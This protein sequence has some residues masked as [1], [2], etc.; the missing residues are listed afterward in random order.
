MAKQHF[1]WLGDVYVKR[2]IFVIRFGH[3]EQTRFQK[4]ATANSQT[5][6]LM[7]E[8]NLVKQETDRILNIKRIFTDVDSKNFCIFIHKN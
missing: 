1:K 2:F 4:P 5:L 7:P 3:G 6:A 8:I